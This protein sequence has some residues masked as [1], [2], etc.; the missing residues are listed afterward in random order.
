[1]LMILSAMTNIIVLYILYIR[2]LFLSIK[3]PFLNLYIFILPFYCTLFFVLNF[4]SSFYTAQQNIYVNILAFRG[5]RQ[6]DRV[7]YHS[8][9][10]RHK[11]NPISKLTACVYS[12]DNGKLFE[13]H[14]FRLTC[15]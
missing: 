9:D 3:R 7:L 10:K 15:Y 8:R 2:F 14:A 12:T 1:M 6:K 11:R 13:V 5:L 4:A